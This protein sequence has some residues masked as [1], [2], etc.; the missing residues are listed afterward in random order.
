MIVQRVNFGYD[1]W[2]DVNAPLSEEVNEISV[3]SNYYMPIS[4]AFDTQ[5]GSLPRL[6]KYQVS[7]CLYFEA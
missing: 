4:V 3:R 5:N 6:D 7:H 2:T 1:L